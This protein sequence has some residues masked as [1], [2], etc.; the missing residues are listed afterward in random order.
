MDSYFNA[1]CTV[2]GKKYHVCQSCQNTGSFVSWRTIAD[3]PA[4]YKIFQILSSHTNRR[5]NE[6]EAKGLLL[7]CDLTE[8]DTFLPDIRKNIRTLLS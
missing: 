2:C 4:C 5:I 8:L 1:V 6:Q 3:S 7:E